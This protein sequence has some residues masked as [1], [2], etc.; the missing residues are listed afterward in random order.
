M[1]SYE[2][3][4]FLL[5]SLYVA[6]KGMFFGN[7]IAF[8]LLFIQ[9]KYEIIPLNEKDYYMETIPISFDLSS[10]IF[11]NLGA[12]TVCFIIIILPAILISKI[13][14]IKSIRFN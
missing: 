13:S 14:P 7:L 2:Y 3:K 8:I 9:Y 12:L 1:T 6:I 4:I 11:I 10:I 5:N